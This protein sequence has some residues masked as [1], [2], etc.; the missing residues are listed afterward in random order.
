MKKSELLNGALSRLRA[1]YG[2]T[3]RERDADMLWDAVLEEICELLVAKGSV[4]V[5]GFGTF[6]YDITPSRLM[7]H[8]KTRE[9]KEVAGKPR[10]KFT[11]SPVV[12]SQLEALQDRERLI[13]WDLED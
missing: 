3:I 1:K 8:V 13:G 2:R 5:R 6:K 4:N 9:I 7:H 12:L 10:V 11:A